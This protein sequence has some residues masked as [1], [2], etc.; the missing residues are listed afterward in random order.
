MRFQRLAHI[1]N[2]HALV[3]CK[4]LDWNSAHK[5]NRLGNGVYIDRH[6][7][8]RQT[9]LPSVLLLLNLVFEHNPTVAE[10]CCE[11]EILFLGGIILHL[12]NLRQFLLLLYYRTWNVVDMNLKA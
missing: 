4:S 7:F 10:A 9:F 2:A 5:R 1:L 11:F 6:A 3:L 12:H 8:F